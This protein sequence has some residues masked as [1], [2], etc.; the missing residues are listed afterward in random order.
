MGEYRK[1]FYVGKNNHFYGY[2]HTEK[3]KRL[4][5][6]KNKG[7]RRSP[8]T[9]FKKGHRPKSWKG[10]RHNYL[11]NKCLERDDNTCLKCGLCDP[12]IMQ[13]DHIKPRVLNPEL[14]NELDNL[15]TLCPNCHE[16]K[17]RKEKGINSNRFLK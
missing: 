3:A 7:K 6:K 14:Y 5:S 2:R 4:I 16:R 1:R 13:V 15:Q 8:A 9:E 17:S 11:V 10:G 12:E